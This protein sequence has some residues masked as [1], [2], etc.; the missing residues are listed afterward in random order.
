MTFSL[1]QLRADAIAI[2]KNA[3]YLGQYIGYLSNPTDAVAFL[4]D[5][6]YG[7]DFPPKEAQVTKIEL[8]IIEPE[9]KNQVCFG[10]DNIIQRIPYKICLKQWQ[11]VDTDTGKMSN[12]DK[13][14]EAMQE[15]FEQL[16]LLG[17]EVE[18]PIYPG[19]PEKMATISVEQA[20]MMVSCTQLAIIGAS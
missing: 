17:Y 3:D 1:L 15:L 11:N 9:I 8:V 16:N 13:L 6:T 14:H 12:P 7:Y 19:R 18:T 20:Y 5:P 2:L 10:G 4:P